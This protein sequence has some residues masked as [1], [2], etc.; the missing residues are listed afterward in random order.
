MTKSE[1]DLLGIDRVFA[2]PFP[3]AH[4]KYLLQ[5]LKI[6]DFAEGPEDIEN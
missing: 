4:F 5:T 1:A 6:H 3:T 2:S